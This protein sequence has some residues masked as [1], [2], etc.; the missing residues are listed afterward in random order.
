MHV[1]LRDIPAYFPRVMFQKLHEP[2]LTALRCFIL[3]GE[4]RRIL[5]AKGFVEF[6]RV[7]GNLALSRAVGDFELKKNRNLAAEDQIVTGK[8]LLECLKN[9]ARTHLA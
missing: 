9:S 5:A 4:M 2:C 8:R 3:L 1:A 7:N 6:G